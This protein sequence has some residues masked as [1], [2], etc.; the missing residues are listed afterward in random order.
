MRGFRG[1]IDELVVLAHAP[2]VEV[3]CNHAR[4]TLVEVVDDADLAAQA[5]R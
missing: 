5:D 3:A 2:N 4:G 1:W